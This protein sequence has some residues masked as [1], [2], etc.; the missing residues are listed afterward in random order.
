MLAISSRFANFSS[1]FTYITCC[2]ANIRSS[3]DNLSSYLAD[4]SSGFTD[5]VLVIEH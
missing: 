1:H 5:S 4:F 2:L 3:F